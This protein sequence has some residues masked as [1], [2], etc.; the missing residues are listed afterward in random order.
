MT[1]PS[2]SDGVTT[3]DRANAGNEPN[4]DVVRAV[5]HAR[6]ADGG[7]VESAALNGS[8]SAQAT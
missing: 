3:A 7:T 1:V 5:R 2:F 6:G 4:D 8:V